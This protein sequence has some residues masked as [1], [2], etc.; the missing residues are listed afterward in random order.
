MNNRKM[1]GISRIDSGATHGWFVRIHR[2]GKTHPKFF[3]DKKNK[4][5][6]KALKLALAHRD[7]LRAKLG[8][9]NNRG[10]RIKRRP[11]NR[12]GVVGVSRSK[13]NY[14]N[15]IVRQYFVVAWR[16]E[17]NVARNKSFSIETLGEK[18]AF[19]LAVKFRKSREKEILAKA[20]KLRRRLS[21]FHLKSLSRH[22]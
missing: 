1:S 15:G 18:K 14:P 3:A 5:K 9:P 21:V 6:T 20:K 17:P 19:D 8:P 13:R 7:K 22:G 16:P 10:Y 12:T 4:G 2:G 11:S